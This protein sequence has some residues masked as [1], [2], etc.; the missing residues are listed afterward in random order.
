MIQEKL[1]GVCFE[2]VT[3]RRSR[4]K[5]TLECLYVGVKVEKT[6]MHIDP[7]VLFTYA[8]TRPGRAN[9]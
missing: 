5:C 3:I 6:V 4:Q 7:L 2:V 9:K 1:D 8:T